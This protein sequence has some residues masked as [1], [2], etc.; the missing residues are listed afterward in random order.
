MLSFPVR[1]LA[2]LDAVHPSSAQITSLFALLVA[3]PPTRISEFFLKHPVDFASVA[4]LAR[5]ASSL[6][7]VSVAVK[8]VVVSRSAPSAHFAP[9]AGVYLIAISVDVHAA[10]MLSTVPVQ[11]DATCAGSSTTPAVVSAVF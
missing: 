7:T 8:V 2:L 5:V 6:E 11:P 9:D 4:V 1:S 3:P 10:S